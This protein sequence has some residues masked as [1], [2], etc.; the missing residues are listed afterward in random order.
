MGVIRAA[1]LAQ[2]ADFTEGRDQLGEQIRRLVWN[3]IPTQVIG[4]HFLA[5]ETNN[6]L[7]WD[8]WLRL[9]LGNGLPHNSLWELSVRRELEEASGANGRLPRG[10][11]T[12]LA[13]KTAG[14]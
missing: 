7:G 4:H 13:T 10:R 2:I 8:G 9:N 3:W 6:Y 1:H 12:P 11:D 14:R 5:G